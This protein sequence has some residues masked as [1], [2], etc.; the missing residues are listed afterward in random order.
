MLTYYHRRK[1][2]TAPARDDFAAVGV[3]LP[4]L[5]GIRLVLLGVHNN[6]GE[7]WLN[8][9]ALGQLRDLQ[10]GTLG[11]DLTFPLSMWV[12]DGAGRWH[13]GRL[14]AWHAE[15]GEAA[16]AVRLIPPLTRSPA[17]LELL[18]IGL[19]AQVRATLPLSWGYCP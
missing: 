3:S 18:A 13:A 4:E 15:N 2:E 7:T 5:E 17:R 9:L 12:R 19:S 10:P 6:G 11:L 14:A 1:P 8:A 16:L